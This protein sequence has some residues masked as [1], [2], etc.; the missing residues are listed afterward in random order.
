MTKAIEFHGTTVVAVRRA[1]RVVLA[2][3]GQVTM[4]STVMK[5]NARKIQRLRGGSV[6]AG[7][8]GSTADA[9]AL[10]ERFEAKLEERGGILRRAAVELAKDW[11]TDRMMRR[12]EALL[13]VADAQ[14]LL[15]ISGNGDVIEPDGSVTAIGSGGPYA[16]AAARALVDATELSA[17]EIAERAL[18]IA[19]E[20]CLYTNDQITVE[21]LGS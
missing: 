12:L 9:F 2:G 19:A 6:L 17:R 1:G 8:A 21:E 3:D 11:R 15:V 18:R 13:I 14:D 16:L 20:I 5:R 10:A 4:G 7:F